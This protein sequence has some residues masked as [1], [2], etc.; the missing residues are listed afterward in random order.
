[1]YALAL[2]AASAIA[3]AAADRTS[4]R[5]LQRRVNSDS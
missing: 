1:M 3:A 5:L 2:G 4:S